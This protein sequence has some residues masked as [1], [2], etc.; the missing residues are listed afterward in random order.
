MSPANIGTDVLFTISSGS[1]F[2]VPATINTTAATGETAR[3]KLPASPIG[4][5]KAIG[6]IP[7]A[8]ASGTTSGTI[9][10]NK[11]IPLPLKRT[12]RMVSATKISGKTKP[13]P[14]P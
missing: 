14:E 9:A 2:V 1:F 3:I 5:D 7:A 13:K 6:L 10:K 4:T 11:A 8:S 12:I